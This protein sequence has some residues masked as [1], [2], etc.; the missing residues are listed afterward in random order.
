MAMRRFESEKRSEPPRARPSP[1]PL[2]GRHGSIRDVPKN[3]RRPSCGR[4]DHRQVHGAAAPERAESLRRVPRLGD[5]IAVVSLRWVTRLRRARRLFGR[6]MARN[7]ATQCTVRSGSAFPDSETNSFAPAIAGTIASRL[8]DVPA[9]TQ[10]ARRDA[11]GRAATRTW[12]AG[13]RGRPCHDVSL[14]Q[15][16][17]WVRQT[18][19]RPGGN[20]AEGFRVSGAGLAGVRRYPGSGRGGRVRGNHRSVSEEAV[21][22]RGEGS[23]ESEDP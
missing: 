3:R 19:P 22:V 4:D 9:E 15:G 21:D 2:L 17:S 1:S 12:F 14:I 16:A 11:E 6:Q 23:E 18:G 7:L 8:R 13:S 10:S 5:A 20:A